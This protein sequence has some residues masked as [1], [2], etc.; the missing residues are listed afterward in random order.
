MLGMSWVESPAP[1][2]TKQQKE[3]IPGGV[4]PKN[5]RKQHF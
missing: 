1:K 5:V 4:K 3:P 2:T